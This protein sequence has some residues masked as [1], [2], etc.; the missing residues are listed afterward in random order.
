MKQSRNL[1]SSS[2]CHSVTGYE[3][4]REES[5]VKFQRLKTIGH[6]K[7][8]PFSPTPFITRAR[9]CKGG[10]G[11]KFM[12]ALLRNIEQVDSKLSW[13]ADSRKVSKNM[14]KQITKATRE[15]DEEYESCQP[16]TSKSGAG[17]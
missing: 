10:M 12:N 1:F 13:S 6:E 16:N 15:S 3:R 17:N 7:H 2:I 11:K 8:P 9:E 4:V 14:L 5:G